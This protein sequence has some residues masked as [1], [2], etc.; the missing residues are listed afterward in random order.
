MSRSP[1][2][3]RHGEKCFGNADII[4]AGSSSKL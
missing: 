1:H 2:I 4:R 3:W